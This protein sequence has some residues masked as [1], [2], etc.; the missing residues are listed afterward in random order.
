MSQKQRKAVMKAERL[1]EAEISNLEQMLTIEDHLNLES[2]LKEIAA[3]IAQNLDETQIGLILDSEEDLIGA[4]TPDEVEVEVAMDSGCVDNVIHPKGLPRDCKPVPN[5]I[6]KHYSGAGGDSIGKYG[7]VDTL[8]VGEHGEVG[9]SWNVANV[10]RALHSIAQVT[11]PIEKPRQDVLFNAAKCV[12]VPEGIVE[13]ILAHVK[14]LLQYNR[15]GN[16]FVAKMKMSS[17]V[18]PATSA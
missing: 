11:G 7:T 13:K 1:L 4:A 16:L 18:R 15:K 10:T 17:F 9:C 3:D 2:T 14:P 6:G 8:L 5:T 12:V